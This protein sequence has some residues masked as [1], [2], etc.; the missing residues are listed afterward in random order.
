MFHKEQLAYYCGNQ[1]CGTM[2]QDVS[3]KT[4]RDLRKRYQ[5]GFRRWIMA[6]SG[7]GVA[8]K[9]VGTDIDTAR[10][11]LK[12]R[13]IDGMN[14]S[15]YGSVWVIDHVVPLRLFDFTNEEDLKVS[16]HYKNTMPLFKEDNLY[17]EGAIDFSI[18]V[19]ELAPYCKIVGL[20]K[21]KLH[22]ENQ[23]LNK[24]LI[25]MSHSGAGYNLIDKQF[26]KLENQ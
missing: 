7:G 26:I 4:M 9:Y 3:K 24:Y 1:L 13:M 23:R 18:R 14:W 15:N 6:A 10:Q 12:D 5:I 21:H 20:L 8:S 2:R 25:K 11:W 17:K 16:L 19:L 22:L